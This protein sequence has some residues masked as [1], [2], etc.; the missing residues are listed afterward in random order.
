MIDRISTHMLDIAIGLPAQGVPVLLERVAAEG[1]VMVVGRGVT[2]QDGRI[3]ALN[4]EP[5]EAGRFRL[6]LDTHEYFDTVHGTVF[7]PAIT[8]WVNLA[9]TRSHYHLP[10]LAGTYSFSS[11]LGS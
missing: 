6:T 9:D 11:Y 3:A 1:D 5:L 7:Y 2:D 4:T 8:V 10:V